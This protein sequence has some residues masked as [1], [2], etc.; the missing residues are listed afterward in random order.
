MITI[1]DEGQTGATQIG[2]LG[3]GQ[4]VDSRIVSPEILIVQDQQ[5]P[6]VAEKENGDRR[7]EG[8]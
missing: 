3:Q 1:W 5:L 4:Q 8:S 2:G 7:V 6:L